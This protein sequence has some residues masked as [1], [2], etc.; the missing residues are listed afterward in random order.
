MRTSIGLLVLL[1]IAQSGCDIDFVA[2]EE[3]AYGSVMLVSQQVAVLEADIDVAL[4]VDGP[5][6]PVQLHGIE[7]PGAREGDHWRFAYSVAV[8]TL[9]PAVPVMIGGRNPRA[10]TLPLLARNGAAEWQS[11]GEIAFPILYGGDPADPHLS[12]E[13]RLVGED[14]G[15]LFSIFS[16]GVPL[17]SPLVLKGELTPAGVVAA[18]IR[19]SFHQEIPD[20]RYP[21]TAGI[22]SRVRIPIRQVER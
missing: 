10:L 2:V 3:R 5:A 21:L 6:P 12:W 18:E 4:P 17:P 15:I 16:R 11:G 9:Q 22:F 13:L 20:G 14:G 7:V 1:A 19:V 8:D